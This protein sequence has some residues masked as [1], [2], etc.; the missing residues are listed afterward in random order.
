MWLGLVQSIRNLESKMPV[1]SKRTGICLK[2]MI[3]KS[4]LSFQTINYGYQTHPLSQ[5]H[6]LIP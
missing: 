5:F 3:K 4:C 1:F 2:T 6:E